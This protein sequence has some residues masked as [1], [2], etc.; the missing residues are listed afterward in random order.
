VK[1]PLASLLAKRTENRRWVLFPIEHGSNQ[2]HTSPK[3]MRSDKQIL[4]DAGTM[5]RYAGRNRVM[6]RYRCWS[7]V[8]QT[9]TPR[10]PANVFAWSRASLALGALN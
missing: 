1:C 6:G 9:S 2:Q 8:Y 10:F 7:S 4:D 3:R 5:T